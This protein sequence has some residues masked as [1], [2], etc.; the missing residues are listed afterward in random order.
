MI[1]GFFH[2]SFGSA[3]N[4]F[5]TLSEPIIVRFDPTDQVDFKLKQAL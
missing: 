4:L 2:A 1:C 5:A 3:A